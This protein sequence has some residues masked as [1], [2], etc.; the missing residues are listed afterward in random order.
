MIGNGSWN[1]DSVRARYA[2]GGDIMLA[3]GEFVNRAPS[4]TPQ[5]LP[6]LQYINQTARAPS[7]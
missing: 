6:T 4:V 5:T 3:G 1:V 7:N 2:C